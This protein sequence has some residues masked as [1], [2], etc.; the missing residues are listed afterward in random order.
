MKSRYVLGAGVLMAVAVVVVGWQPV[1]RAFADD[2]DDPEAGGDRAIELTVYSEDFA[3][4]REM[5]PFKLVKGANA[6]AVGDVSKELD[7]QSVLLRWLHEGKDD[8][9]Q[10][11]GNA[12]D[13]GIA[14]SQSLLKQ[15]LGEQVELVR[16]GDDGREADRRKGRVIVAEGGR[17][18]VFESDGKLMVQPEGTIIATSRAGAPTLP[19]LS[20]QVQSPSPQSGRLDVT[21]LTRGLQWSADYAAILDPNDEDRMDL[22]CTATVVNRTGVRYPAAEVSLAVGAPNRAVRTVEA[23]AQA[24]MA[25]D[26]SPWYAS[27]RPRRNRFAVNAELR[28]AQAGI[29]AAAVGSSASAGEFHTYPLKSPATIVPEQLNR[30]AMLN[31]DKVRVKRDYSF[32]APWLD[33][34]Q[35]PQAPRGTVIAGLSF[36]NYVRNGLGQPLPAG[37]LRVYDPDAEG[38]LRYAGAATIPSTAKDGKIGFTLSNAFD[39]T[40]AY[41]TVATQKVGKRTYR[42][43][44]EVKLRNEKATP[45]KV[46]VVQDLGSGWRIASESEKHVKLAAETVQWTVPIKAGGET[47]LRFSVDFRGH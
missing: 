28:Y 37:A 15:R 19:Q 7:P 13:L 21:Y 45:A 46:R 41:R 5:R 14:D 1:S 44:V 35:S 17:P 39:L 30:L 4:V 3:M 2:E 38:R 10:I 9:P 31:S 18:S 47:T 25:E 23:A 34:Y 11:T 36:F 24:P 22:E 27:T 8:G 40:A 6:V 33:A 12:Y 42:K 20:V 16:Y 43:K 26:A 32:R 29:P